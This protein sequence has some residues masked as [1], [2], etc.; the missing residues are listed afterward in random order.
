M[1]EKATQLVLKGA[2]LIGCNFDVTGPV[3]GGIA[4]ATRALISPIEMAT[5]KKAYFVGKPNPLMM[6]HGLNMLGVE[7][8]DAE[9]VLQGVDFLRDSAMG[10]DVPIG[11][12]VLV[13]GGGNVAIDVALTAKR[14]GAKNVT[15]ICLEARDEMPAWQH[16]IEEALEGDIEIVNS[17]GPK[18]FF[19]DKSNKVSGIEFKTC[20]AVFDDEG[21]FNPQYDDNVCQPFF[22]DTIIIAI[23]QSAQL[24]HIETQ[25]IPVTPRGG[26][27]ADPI[28]LQT[29]L[30]WV[31]AGGDAFY[32]PKSVVDAV[33]CGKEAA[34]SIHRFLNG[35]DLAAGREQNWEFDKPD[36][37]NEVHMDRTPV[38]CL[39]PEAREC[40]FLEVSF[41]YNEDEAKTE[42]QR[43]LECGICSECYSA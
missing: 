33:S 18:S 8:E 25:G 38:R 20:T 22:G 3:D 32:G 36:T 23:G 2:K 1:M 7:N 16:E 9:G 5:G 17:F 31:F 26:L 42:A 37:A 40:N 34:E 15:L 35:Q 11:E 28:T 4:P 39:D 19:I 29:K 27:E 21:R 30:D 24:E 12:D 41:G 13:V 6:R 14:K 43:C 10:I